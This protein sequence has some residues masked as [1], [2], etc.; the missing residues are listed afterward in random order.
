MKRAFI[1]GA[2]RGIG[3]ALTQALTQDHWEVWGTARQKNRLPNLKNFHALEVDHSDT[4]QTRVI[5]KKGLQEAGYF[6]LLIN[7]AGYSCFG[8]FETMDPE[9]FR[10]QCE[11][12][13]F[14]P[15][16]LIRLILPEMKQRKQ[17]VIMNISSLAARFPVP[18]MA[19]YNSSKAALSAFS[20]TLDLELQNS[21]VQIIDVQL[22]DILT[23]FNHS[24]QRH[25]GTHV[26]CETTKAAWNRVDR[27]MR[28]APSADWAAKK[29]LKTM[30][31]KPIPRRVMIGEYFQAKIAPFLQRISPQ[32]WV[33]Y[34]MKRYFG[35]S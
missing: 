6:D 9:V 35:I 25:P 31:Q 28:D 20:T 3:L 33:H 8:S 32:S 15:L 13:F 5:F 7:N 16:E 1:T 14:A 24:M 11:V 34:G 10:K 22:G 17:G 26:G 4:D 27:L 19:A 18:F 2:S 30:K 29:I 21:G 12:L 23:E